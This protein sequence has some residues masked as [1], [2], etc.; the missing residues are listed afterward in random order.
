MRWPRTRTPAPQATREEESTPLTTQL[1]KVGVINTIN[2]VKTSGKPS[3]W[4]QQAATPGWTRRVNR[5]NRVNHTNY[6]RAW[7]KRNSS[8]KTRR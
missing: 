8:S 5:V 6:M 2:T 3:A 7:N 1:F 4:S